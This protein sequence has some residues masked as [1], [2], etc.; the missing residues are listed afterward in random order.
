MQFN[1][2]QLSSAIQY[3]GVHGQGAIPGEVITREASKLVD[4]WATMLHMRQDQVELKDGSERCTLVVQAL[5]ERGES[6]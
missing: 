5:Q 6:Q 2:A 3:W 4:V 1:T